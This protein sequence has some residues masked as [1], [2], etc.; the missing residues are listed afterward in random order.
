MIGIGSDH[1]GFQL[2]EKIIEYLKEQNIVYIDYGTINEDSV[3]YPKYAFKVGEAIKNKEIKYGILICTT[4][5]GMCIA[6]N[7]VKGIRCAKVDNVKE[8]YLTRFHNNANVLA[9]SSTHSLEETKEI[10]KT[11]LETEF[12]NEER[13]IRRINMIQ[14]YEETNEY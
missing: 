14:K 6:C 12:S 7:K 9:L 5:I 1:G 11:F 8:A 4:G 10:V 2:K 3:D 13:H